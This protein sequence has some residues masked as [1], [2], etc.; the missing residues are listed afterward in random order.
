[1]RVRRIRDIE[2]SL[3]FVRELVD[4]AYQYSAA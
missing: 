1:M 2:K 4:A 3:A